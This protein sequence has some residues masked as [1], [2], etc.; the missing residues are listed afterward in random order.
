MSQFGFRLVLEMYILNLKVIGR[1]HTFYHV[2]A[3]TYSHRY[4]CT[5]SPACKQSAKKIGKTQCC[6]WN[7][8][9]EIQSHRPNLLKS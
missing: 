8:Q 3:Y 2:H 1:A 9:R 4:A 6:L 7:I 5:H